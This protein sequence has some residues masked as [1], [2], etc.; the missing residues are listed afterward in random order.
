MTRDQHNSPIWQRQRQGRITATVAHDIVSLQPKTSRN[1]VLKK[2]MKYYKVR[3]TCRKVEAVKF[4]LKHERKAKETYNSEMKTKHD[5]FS[6]TE[7]G[8]YVDCTCPIFAATP[9]GQR[10]CEC[11]GEELI[12]VKCSYKHRDSKTHEICDPSFYLDE[13]MK[14]KESH[15]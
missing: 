5:N 11:H 15:R 2:I 6:A 4:G 3:K 1:N 7:C 10:K 9:D 14:L 12:E 8:L 13:K